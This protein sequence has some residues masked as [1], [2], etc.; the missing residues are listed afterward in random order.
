MFK[1]D[2][3][4]FRRRR[5]A[6][7]IAER[8]PFSAAKFVKRGCELQRL[9]Q[10]PW[11]R[12]QFGDYAT[13]DELIAQAAQLSDQSSDNPAGVCPCGCRREHKNNVSQTIRNPYG[14]GFDVVYFWSN[15]CKSK[16]NQEGMGDKPLARLV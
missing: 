9:E 8:D 2:A 13:I 7:G 3:E 16:W 14:R 5:R 11:P 10:L 6:Q 1:H 15:A 12:S 4:Y